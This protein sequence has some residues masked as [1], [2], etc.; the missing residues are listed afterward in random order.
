MEL[1]E[2]VHLIDKVPAIFCCSE[3]FRI[4]NYSTFDFEK[5]IILKSLHDISRLDSSNLGKELSTWKKFQ[6]IDFKEH[7]EPWQHDW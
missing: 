5:S 6:K 3:Y 7:V 2:E 4:K 1:Q